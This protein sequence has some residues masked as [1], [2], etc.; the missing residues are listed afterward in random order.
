MGPQKRAKRTTQDI[1]GPRR[2]LGLGEPMND[3]LKTAFYRA[4]EFGAALI[5]AYFWLAGELNAIQ[6]DLSLIRA[7]THALRGIKVQLETH[8]DNPAHREASVRL[9][10]LEKTVDSL[11]QKQAGPR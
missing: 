2:E 3:V 5:A 9:I 10:T 1:D 4:G 7:D 6:N 11:L 8:I